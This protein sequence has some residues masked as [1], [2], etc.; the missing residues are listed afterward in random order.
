M[1]IILIPHILVIRGPY[2]QKRC[3]KVKRT[4]I[5]SWRQN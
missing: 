3:R 5:H 4:S 2:C 1:I